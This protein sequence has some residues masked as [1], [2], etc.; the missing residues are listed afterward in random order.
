[1]DSDNRCLKKVLSPIKPHKKKKS[2]SN[3]FWVTKAVRGLC[4]N[5]KK[6]LRKKHVYQTSEENLVIHEQGISPYYA[7]AKVKNI[8][9]CKCR[10]IL[11]S[12]EE[13]PKIQRYEGRCTSLGCVWVEKPD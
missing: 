11:K 4:N 8:N 6:L 1:M 2:N 3:F 12:E 7:G 9:G 5:L 10:W 13:L